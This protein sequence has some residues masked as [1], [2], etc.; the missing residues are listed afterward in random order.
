MCSHILTALWLLLG[1]AIAHEEPSSCLLQKEGSQLQRAVLEQEVRQEPEHS[2]KHGESADSEASDGDKKDSTNEKEGKESKDDEKT[3]KSEGKGNEPEGS[4]ETKEGGDDNVK[5]APLASMRLELR[6]PI[7]I[8]D[9][10]GSKGPLDVFLGKL[11]KS[12]AHTAGIP[13]D[14]VDILG[15]RGGYSDEGVSFQEKQ[16]KASPQES[17][18]L[19]GEVGHSTVDIEVLPGIHFNDLSPKAVFTVWKE[20]LKRSDS[21]LR[22]GPMKDYVLGATLS[23]R[24]GVEGLLPHEAVHP[25]GASR[26]RPY[27][28]ALVST[29]CLLLMW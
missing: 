13:L 20:A 7:P 18:Q 2:E 1:A 29:L 23:E 9:L 3:S 12:L 14:R 24:E 5:D 6:L 17:S 27:I 16:L 26:H 10:K 8:E 28:V 22:K 21:P 25:N 4:N 15:I 11:R 19:A